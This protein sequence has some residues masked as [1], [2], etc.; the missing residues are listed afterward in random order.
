MKNLAEEFIERLNSGNCDDLYG[1]RVIAG[2]HEIS[3]AKYEQFIRNYFGGDMPA[4]LIR[5]VLQLGIVE[6]LD[7][8]SLC[9]AFSSNGP[10]GNQT[11]S[12]QLLSQCDKNRYSTRLF[13]GVLQNY[14]VDVF[15]F[16]RAINDQGNYDVVFSAL[17][18]ELP[19]YYGDISHLHP[20]LTL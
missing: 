15:H 11:L 3:K 8:E 1:N 2:L 19:Q 9:Y 5:T 12:V 4:P 18:G 20:L 10:G 14:D 17:K 6:G 13:L 16:S 7:C